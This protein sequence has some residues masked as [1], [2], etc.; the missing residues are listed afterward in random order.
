MWRYYYWE[1]KKSVEDY[2]KTIDIKFLKKYWYLDKWVDY[3][4]LWL[5]WKINWEDNWNIWV[6]VNKT[7]TNW[8]LRVTFTQTS[9]DWEK[10]KLD[11]KIDL[12]ST[13]CNY[14]WIRWWFLCPCKWNRCS[15]LYLQNNWIFA[16]RKTLDL[17][18]EDQKK[19]KKWR[20][21]DRIFPK[22]YEAERLY[23]TIKYKFRN[24]KETRK[25]KRFLRLIRKNIPDK[26]IYLKQIEYILG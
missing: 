7:E 16:I 26:K 21:F 2:S 13:P 1:W 25:Y 22:D 9:Y 12:V 15:I 11:Y 6:E 3:K 18:Y 24:W 20:E 14:W 17:C 8:S 10:K 23:K 19:S 5:Y 4:K